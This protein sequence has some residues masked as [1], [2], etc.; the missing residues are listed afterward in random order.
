MYIPSDLQIK[1]VLPIKEEKLEQCAFWKSFKVDSFG[2]ISLYN[3]PIKQSSEKRTID[4]L[5]N[6]CP[7][8]AKQYRL[9]QQK[10]IKQ[11]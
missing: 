10:K 4:S 2:G 8:K 7:K 9:K 5:V 1:A 11:M 3:L 6:G